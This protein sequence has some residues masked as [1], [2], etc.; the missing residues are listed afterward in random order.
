MENNAPPRTKS[1]PYRRT[2]GLPTSTG[3][4]LRVTPARSERMVMTL[5][6][7][8][9]R[10]GN[11][12][13]AGKLGVFLQIPKTFDESHRSAIAFGRAEQLLLLSW[14]LHVS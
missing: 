8:P 7:A 1:G 12:V 10:L 4:T 9:Q 11:F 6:L 3:G 13:G 14:I 5:I 2:F